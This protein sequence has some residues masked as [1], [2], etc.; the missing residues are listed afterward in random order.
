L[1]KRSV[2]VIGDSL[3]A[4]GIMQSLKE[5]NQVIVQGAAPNLEC[6]SETFIED[7][8]CYI[9]ALIIVGGQAEFQK[10]W[11]S[12]FP[13]RPDLPVLWA[14]ITQDQ[15]LVVTCASVQVNADDIMMTITKLPKR[16]FL[17]IKTQS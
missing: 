2:Y 4:Q 9:D 11:S 3:L 12:V 14:D 13:I 10:L 7:T 15:I 8:N 1:E 5:Q 16:R 6:L 17:E